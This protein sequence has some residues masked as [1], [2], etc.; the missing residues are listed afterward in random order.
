MRGKR[1][2]ITLDQD[3]Y[4]WAFYEAK[5]KKMS[6]SQELR[7]ITRDGVAHRMDLERQY[8]AIEVEAAKYGR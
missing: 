4:E 7:W 5:R 8:R 6:L 3:I 2:T 1:V